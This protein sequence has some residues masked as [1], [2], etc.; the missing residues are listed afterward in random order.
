MPS[1]MPSFI[2][3]QR[4]F[5]FG[6]SVVAFLL[7]TFQNCAQQG[8]EFVPQVQLYELPQYKF[9]AKICNDIRFFNQKGN[10]FL[11]IVDMSA[12]NVG[13]WFY[14][15]VGGTKFWYFNPTLA[16]DPEGSRFEAIRYF[17]DHCGGQSGAQFSVIGFSNTAGILSSGSAPALACSNVGFVTPQVAKAQ[18]DLLKARQTLDQNWFF[19]WSKEKNK[20]LTG[21]TPESL[22][23]GV[24]SYGSAMSCSEKILISDLTSSA[25]IPADNYYVFFLSDG[26]PEDKKGTGCKLTAKTPEEKEACYLSSV[27]D[28]M[29]MIRTAAI[30]K[31]KNLRFTGVYY[32]PD[33]TVPRVLDSVAKEG[34]TSGAVALK[35]FSGEQTA[36]CSLFV[37]QSA[38]EY[39]PDSFVAVD[40]T[41]MR[42]NGKI[43][44]DSDMD[45]VDD[46]TEFAE[47]TDPQNPR[48][49]GIPG[50]LDGICH[51]LGG[52]ARCKEERSK[53]VC[54]PNQFNA[55]G[56]SDCDYKILGLDR[57]D[58]GSWGLD[59]DK[60]GML[61]F[62]EII[63]GSNPGVPDMMGDPDGDGWM[64]RDEIV[65]GTDPF[66]PDAAYPEYLMTLF[67]TVY[68]P[69]VN[70]V[71]CPAGYWKLD[72]NRLLAAATVA[73]QSYEGE[74]SYLN[75]E[76]NVH[77]VMVFY[78]SIAQN[79]ST[80]QNEY[81]A[82]WVDVL[83]EKSR[84]KTTNPNTN[85]VT[86]FETE[87][88][89]PSMEELKQTD[90]RLIG[91]VEP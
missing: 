73:V 24:T 12:S 32:G 63:K 8:L 55:V 87:T 30:T 85:R 64:T 81:F 72:A 19:Q 66:V 47:G 40:L 10:K 16:T 84:S 33:P 37:S 75:H 9:S 58:V 60:D 70:E 71:M 25:T 13:D 88:A 78:R 44:A 18:V 23:L 79:S 69:G 67:K 26:I 17:I 31:T 50:V 2:S 76:K 15:E 5:L 52:V 82:A 90:F 6:L 22:I 36:L 68:V 61:D 11:F 43:V 77:K 62:I 54:H 42:K 56:L 38:L 41:A 21:S 1:R 3:S 49:T 4:K 74:S 57:R 86:D 80:P 65:R 39:K 45:G 51:R 14:E 29:Q 35:S 59:T 53:V 20:Y 91:T 89:T 27:S 46:E 28:S 7:I 34:G 48:S 83:L